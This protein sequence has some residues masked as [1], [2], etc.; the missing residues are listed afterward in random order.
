MTAVDGYRGHLDYIGARSSCLHG[1]Y[2]G[3]SNVTENQSALESPRISGSTGMQQE[4]F[5]DGPRV[6]HALP[7]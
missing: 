1:N 4:G 3:N 2:D 6:T 5:E 7:I